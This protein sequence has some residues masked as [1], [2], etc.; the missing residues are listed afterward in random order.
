[1]NIAIID[2]GSNTIRLN[3]YQTE[4]ESF[5]LL[6]TKKH[7]A[8]LASYI[9]D[10]ELSLAGEKKL[11]QILMR[12]KRILSVVDIDACYG[13]ATASLRKVS[14]GQEI[15][16]R[17]AKITA[18]NLQ[19]LSEDEE[20]RLGN[21]AIKKNFELKKGVSVDIGG[22]STEIVYFNKQNSRT[23]PLAEGSLSLYLRGV[24]GIFPTAKEAKKL[25]K[26]IRSELPKLAPASEILA[27]GGTARAAGKIVAALR[28]DSGEE[29][30]R[31]YNRRELKALIQR[32]IDNEQQA[33]QALLKHAPERV[34]TLV[35]GL[36]ILVEILEA[37]ESKQVRVSTEGVREG[38]LIDKIKKLEKTAK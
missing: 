1:M 33:V 2:I 3:V 36:L 22:G 16:T 37:T 5:R 17:L 15:I 31:S 9:E 32:L 23:Y 12:L 34:H 38:Y 27:I 29:D 10:A 21:L 11:Q 19:V 4:G 18:L 20:A 26:F 13:F 24:S 6:I 25:S 35:P 28:S 8:G 30:R 14:N 7:T